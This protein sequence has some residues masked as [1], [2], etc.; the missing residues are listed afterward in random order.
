MGVRWFAGV[1]VQA[2]RDQFCLAFHR[3][4]AQG[5][6]SI[7]EQLSLA[8]L[9]QPFSRVTT[10]LRK[11]G[12]A[13]VEGARAAFDILQQP[14]FLIDRRGL[15]RRTNAWAEHL[16]QADLNLSR[17]KLSI[18]NNTGGTALLQAHIDAVLWSGRDPISRNLDRLTVQRPGKPPLTFQAHLVQGG[19]L[20]LFAPA[21]AILI[22]DDP[23]RDS[24]PNATALA[25]LLDL[26]D[27]EARLCFHLARSFNLRVAADHSGLSYESARS[28]LKTIFSKT[29]TANQ[30]ELLALLAKL[31]LF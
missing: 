2:E 15:V 28:Y 13:E 10:L 22:V 5:I 17:G 31:R 27:G 14:A 26:S 3:T 4:P 6:F 1:L 21:A 12:A 20:H 19:I 30:A 24:L 23:D 18:E 16:L 7:E 8:R 29:N 11:I 25:R 9:S